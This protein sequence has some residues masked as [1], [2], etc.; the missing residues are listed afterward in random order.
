M[1]LS[2]VRTTCHLSYNKCFKCLFCLASGYYITGSLLHFGGSVPSLPLHLGGRHHSG[3]PR[4]V[5]RVTS[6]DHPPPWLVCSHHRGVNSAD[7][8]RPG[9]PCSY[10]SNLTV[11]LCGRKFVWV[12]GV[13]S[14]C[15]ESVCMESVFEL[16]AY[17]GVRKLSVVSLA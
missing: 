13:E 6:M 9:Q 3:T 7:P 11:E 4:P 16:S 1:F 8:I 17:F 5:C 12:A 10:S 14:V 15:V 2:F